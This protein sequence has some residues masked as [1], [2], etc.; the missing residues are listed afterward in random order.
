MTTVPAK[1]APDRS[2]PLQVTGR[3]K[4]ALD[5]MVWEGLQYADAAKFAG[6]TARAMRKALDKSHVCRYLSNGK[7]A[8]RASEGPRILKRLVVLAH[9]DRNAKPLWPHAAR[10]STSRRASSHSG[11]ARKCRGSS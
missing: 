9:Q 4:V 1:R 8:L 11:S 10:S 5:A 7:A 3:L 2:R 6:L